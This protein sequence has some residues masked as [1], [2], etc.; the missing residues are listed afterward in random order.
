MAT[1]LAPTSS[2]TLRSLSWTT[3]GQKGEK[4]SNRS[5]TSEMNSIIVL[6][7]IS[8]VTIVLAGCAG[9]S[10]AYCCYL[11]RTK[12]RKMAA[13]ELAQDSKVKHE[14]FDKSQTSMDGKTPVP[15]P[16]K[17]AVELI[18]GTEGIEGDFETGARRSA[19]S[20]VDNKENQL[21]DLLRDVVAIND[22]LENDL[23][24]EINNVS[25]TPAGEG[26]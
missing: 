10:L 22:A 25:Q 24:H 6:A 7:T 3:T 21:G 12:K 4:Q 18:E 13:L 14:L 20:V 17:V 15:N 8:F 5:K 11:R 1:T 23:L 19:I 9:I 26:V 2:P 16:S